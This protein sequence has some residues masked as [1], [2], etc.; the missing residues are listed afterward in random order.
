MKPE[1]H[2]IWWVDAETLGDTGWMDLTE[3]MESAKV[4]P[5]IMQTVGF[6][7]VDHEDYVAI[8]DSL[9][10]KECGHVTKIPKVMIHRREILVHGKQEMGRMG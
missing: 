1:I 7:L 5:P 6:V 8:T 3:A 4:E 2:H 10:D 9:G